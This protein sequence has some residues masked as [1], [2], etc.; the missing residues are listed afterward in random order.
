MMTKQGMQFGLCAVLTTAGA[1]FAVTADAQTPGMRM[2][3]WPGKA[4]MP[5]PVQA[6]T[7]NFPSPE[8]PSF[9]EVQ[10]SV[11]PDYTAVAPAFPR[12]L[13]PATAF[14]A[15]ARVSGGQAY[16]TG[17]VPYHGGAA[18]QSAVVT[19]PQPY[20]M[21]RQ[22]P[23]AQALDA[24]QQVAGAY[25]EAAVIA[26]TPIPSTPAPHTPV[27][28][29]PVPH[30]PPAVHQPQ[31]QPQPQP[32]SE[33]E[34][35]AQSEPAQV[36]DPMAPRAD[37]PIWRLTG[38]QGS[39]AV[40]DAPA[41]AQTEAEP[42]PHQPSADA[43]DPSGPRYYSVHRQAGRAPDPTILPAPFFLDSAPVDLAEPPPP[44]TL[45]R[46]GGLAPSVAGGDL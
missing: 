26:S 12:S 7:D 27:R 33:D 38:R 14:G 8:T 3:N 36:H 35:A 20:A 15:P 18:P 2:L 5:P 13:T 25:H 23:V 41:P 43:A 24:R 40:S 28:Q 32:G 6:P 37:A 45:L 19:P 29:T 42:Q 30:T 31:P 39:H 17:P 16:V 46:P 21:G 10:P 34:L 44:P 22:A 4:D 1:L 11:M 9:V